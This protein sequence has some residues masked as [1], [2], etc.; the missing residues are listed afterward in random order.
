MFLFE[1]F[2]Y[3]VYSLQRLYLSVLDEFHAGNLDH[4]CFIKKD[5]IYS[6]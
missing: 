5:G 3:K 2:T 4:Y 1:S 6:N